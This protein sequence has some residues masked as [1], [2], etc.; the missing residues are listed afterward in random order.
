L[1]GEVAELEQM[2]RAVRAPMAADVRDQ[3]WTRF[4]AQ[5]PAPKK[6][7]SGHAMDDG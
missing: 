1:P 3:L 7:R 6:R 5:V 4:Q 2:L